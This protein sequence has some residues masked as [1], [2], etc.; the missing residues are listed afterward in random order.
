MTG[1]NASTSASTSADTVNASS[2]SWK[3][4]T[5]EEGECF[6]EP[7]TCS[8]CLADTHTTG[9]TCVLTEQGICL[10]VEEYEETLSSAGGTYYV[11]GNAT[12]CSSSRNSY[13]TSSNI[14][15]V[16]LYSCESSAWLSYARKRLPL[17]VLAVGGSTPEGCSFAT[18]TVNAVTDGGAESTS[19]NSRAA[20]SAA[21]SSKDTLSSDDKCTWYQNTTLCSKP[22][23]CYDCLNTLTDSG[24][25]CTITPDGYC[26]TLARSYN[27]K[28]DFRSPSSSGAANGYY[29]PSTN[30]TY[31]EATDQACTH[32]SVSSSA[33]N[34]ASYCV[35]SDGCICVAFCQS[36]DWEA[37]V[38]AEKCSASTSATS[39][40]LSASEFPWKTFCV[41]L[42]LAVAVVL[43]V[44]L[45]TWRV[46]QLVLIRRRE[47]E[48]CRR[49][50]MRRST[51]E[52]ELPAW[53]ALRE[54][55]I[56]S[57]VDPVGEGRGRLRPMAS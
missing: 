14:N 24:G 31:C 18:D 28:L 17:I 51:L 16:L 38:L 2:C 9:E 34:S 50:E 29:Y 40:S 26:A 25:A 21:S 35:G 36:A 44:I 48:R 7:R 13:S 43:G 23:S 5:S 57:K 56:D 39:S 41:F 32:C 6:L 37:T 33:S 8:E 1:R 3:T 27:Y 54:E 20:S 47:A 10:S 52:L 15:C 4:T 11:A 19:D 55:L 42:G 49:S 22:R 12:Y 30:T 53:K 45:G 46:R